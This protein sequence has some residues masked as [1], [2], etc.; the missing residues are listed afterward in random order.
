METL[1]N[2]LL[3]VAKAPNVL[4]DPA[5]NKIFTRII[6]MSG[7]GIS[8]LQ[9]MAQANDQQIV[10]QEQPVPGQPPEM[11][12]VPNVPEPNPAME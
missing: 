5:L 1:N 8:P 6:E 10:Q 2:I 4:T 9:L 12:G 7:A 3:T 11:A